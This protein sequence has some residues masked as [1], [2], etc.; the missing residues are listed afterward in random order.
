MMMAPQLKKPIDTHFDNI[1][2]NDKAESEMITEM[3]TQ[4]MELPVDG[5]G[6]I[7]G[8]MNE[9]SLKMVSEPLELETYA[10]AR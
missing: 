2:I 5:K 9:E 4:A 10:C 6:E 1:L 7:V 3:R 8:E